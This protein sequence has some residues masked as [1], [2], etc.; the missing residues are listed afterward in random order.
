MRSF[1]LTAITLPIDMP[2]CV[3]HCYNRVSHLSMSSFP[4]NGKVGAVRLLAEWA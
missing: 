3:V 1:R 4:L 2:E